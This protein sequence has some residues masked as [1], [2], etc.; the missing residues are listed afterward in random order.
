[1]GQQQHVGITQVNGDSFLEQAL[2]KSQ[3]EALAQACLMNDDKRGP[4]I[5]SSG[6]MVQQKHLDIVRADGNVTL[7]RALVTS[8]VRQTGADHY[9]HLP[10]TLASVPIPSTTCLQA[11]TS[12]RSA[13]GVEPVLRRAVTLPQQNQAVVGAVPVEPYRCELQSM[14]R[15]G[16]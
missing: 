12:P 7:E 9:L 16:L 2:V 5:I 8:G 3:S 4:V 13:S 6:A 15:A 10:F 11:A 14:M 1:M